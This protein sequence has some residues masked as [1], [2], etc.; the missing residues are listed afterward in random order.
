[1]MTALLVDDDR[2]F[3]AM[4]AATLGREGIPTTLAHS[5]HE[6]RRAL[7]SGSFDLVILDR[8][9]PD[10]DGLASLPEL[11]AAAGEAV[12][13]VVTANGDIRGAVDA[14]RLGAADYVAKPVDLPDLL[15]KAR[16]ALS[17]H[18]L[19]ERLRH[20]EGAL[21][22]RRALVPPASP[23]MRTA[24]ALLERVADTSARGAVLLLGETGSG[25]EVLAWHL[26][27][28][29]LGEA[30]PFI[31]VNCA[32]LPE[33]TAE[34]E[35]F[36]HEKGAFTD[37]RTSRQGLVE[38][39]DGGTLFLDEVGELSP[40]MQARLLTFL[41]GGRFRRMGGGTE[42]RSS[43]RVVAATNRD[44]QARVKDGSFRED[45][46]FRLSVFRVDIPP[47]R[48]RREDIPSL[49]AALLDRLAREYGV[50]QPPKLTAE[51]LDR[52][53]RYPFPG[54][55]RELRN[56]LERALVLETSGELRL[57]WLA[58]GAPASGSPV[59]DAFTSSE[60]ETLD[61]LER[62]YA[63]W[64]LEQMG[65]RRQDTARALGISHPT[66]NKLVREG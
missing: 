2:A 54:N 64:A 59:P 48:E 24:V 15:L 60:V 35:L 7:A 53:E 65:G 61:A 11:R 46:W 28:R 44:L 22:S 30:Q 4:A 12:V 52:L 45:L 66:F 8:R 55:V 17:A 3:C 26:H 6:A 9:L 62:R 34:S 57:K 13:M 33:T 41:D 58:A 39:A 32:S 51:A 16:R 37:A 56:L 10:G 49:A 19:K 20:S 47:L 31:Q 14:V 63:R 40:P 1:M 38:L 29:A 43:A 50:R 42:R 36:G 23:S 18:G 5:L 21:S 27:R 25:K